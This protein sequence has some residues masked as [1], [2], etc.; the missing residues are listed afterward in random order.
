MPPR[1]EFKILE[2]GIN[3]VV[4]ALIRNLVGFWADGA[5][6]RMRPSG[7]KPVPGDVHLR[8]DLSAASS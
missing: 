7:K 2:R 5:N 3:H 8:V 1:D 4:S 6:A